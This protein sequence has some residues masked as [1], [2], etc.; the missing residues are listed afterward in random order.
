MDSRS[1]CLHVVDSEPVV[2]GA[3]D[4]GVLQERHA[5]DLRPD[6]QGMLARDSK[7]T[8]RPWPGVSEWS[9][10]GPVLQFSSKA[11][12]ALFMDPASAYV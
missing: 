11:A 12:S 5:E 6:D 8:P 2:R 3:S 1:V 10:T 9:P 7:G 4:E